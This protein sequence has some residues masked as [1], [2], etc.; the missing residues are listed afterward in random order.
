VGDYARLTGDQAVRYA[1]ADAC[2]PVLKLIAAPG[3]RFRGPRACRLSLH[4]FGAEITMVKKI[5]SKSYA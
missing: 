4:F 5:D 1:V 2:G 3:L